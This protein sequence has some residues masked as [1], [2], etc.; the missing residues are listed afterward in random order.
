MKLKIVAIILLLFLLIF[1]GYKKIYASKIKEQSINVEQLNILK[2][3]PEDN[4]LLFISNFD[5]SN[6]I[7]NLE[8]DKNTKD[9]DKFVLIKDSILDYLGIDLGNNNLDDIY[10][11][12]LIISTSENNKKLKDDILMVFKIKPEK[13]LDDVLHLSNKIDQ[14]DEIIPINRENKLNYLNFIYR[15]KDNY[16]IASSTK[17]LII[18]CINSSNNFKEKKFQYKKELLSLRNQKKHIIY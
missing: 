3:L 10:N 18:S 14:V 7:H 11:N 17:K 13:N 6:I 16:I 9:Q 8:N 1:F 2:Y 4:K 5:I 15:T 12:E